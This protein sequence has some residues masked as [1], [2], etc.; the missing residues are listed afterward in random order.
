MSGKV[1]YVCEFC[2][3]P[4]YQ[5]EQGKFL[6]LVGYLTKFFNAIIIGNVAK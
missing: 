3:L 6:I 2:I 5:I 1:C 4:N